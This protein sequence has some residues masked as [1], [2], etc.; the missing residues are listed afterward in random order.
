MSEIKIIPKYSKT[1]YRGQISTKNNDNV[2]SFFE[3]TLNS[4][5]I[6]HLVQMIKNY[7]FDLIDFHDSEHIM[8]V[9]IYSVD[10]KIENFY[11]ITDDNRNE[12]YDEIDADNDIFEKHETATMIYQLLENKSYQT[13]QYEVTDFLDNKVSN[14]LVEITQGL[15]NKDNEPL[16]VIKNDSNY[17]YFIYYNRSLYELIEQKNNRWNENGTNKEYTDEIW[18]KKVEECKAA[19][20]LE[21]I[22]KR[23]GDTFNQLQITLKE[24]Q[25]KVLQQALNAQKT[26]SKESD[27][28]VKKGQSEL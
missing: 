21:T 10:V 26:K 25:V 28:N 5:N 17:C 22:K 4:D 2:Y 13:L 23:V 12:V 24:N 14:D 11:I 19:Y 8:W 20:G 3:N 7:S 15:N 9:T 16:I 6:D 18:N 1:F 27:E